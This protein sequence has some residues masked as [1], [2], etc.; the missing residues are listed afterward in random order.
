MNQFE[1]IQEIVRAMFA[2]PGYKLVTEITMLNGT[3]RCFVTG[4]HP[5]GDFFSYQVKARINLIMS[6]ISFSLVCEDGEC[7]IG[8]VRFDS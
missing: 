5:S 7:P 8:M 6:M 3:F 2:K 4:R 1:R